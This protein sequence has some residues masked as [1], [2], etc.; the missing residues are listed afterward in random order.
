MLRHLPNKETSRVCQL[1]QPL[2]LT[3][4]R[5]QIPDNP[6]YARYQKFLWWVGVRQRKIVLTGTFFG[7]INL[8]CVAL[9]PGVLGRGIQAIADESSSELQ[10]QW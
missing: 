4:Y 1:C 7:I 3:I 9:M 5:Y 10:K 2:L 6:I 8:L